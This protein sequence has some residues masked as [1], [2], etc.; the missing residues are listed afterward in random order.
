MDSTKENTYIVFKLNDELYAI[1]VALATEA[2]D[3]LPTTK[4][5][6]SPDYLRG[7]INLRGEIVPIVVIRLLLN[8]P[9]KNDDIST[10]FII[11][12]LKLMDSR[13]M[14]GIVVDS[15]CEVID[16]SDDD[17]LPVP[18]IGCNFDVDLL[19]G[20]IAHNGAYVFILNIPHL[21]TTRLISSNIA[22]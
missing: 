21:F 10:S 14:A 5:P 16:I 17:I 11:V 18:E 4:V 19:S 8:M 1:P 15:M 2:I 3:V 20:M 13:V 12:N 7:V 6:H 22:S 9:M